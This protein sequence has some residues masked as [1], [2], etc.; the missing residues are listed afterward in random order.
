MSAVAADLRFT[1]PWRTALPTLIALMLAILLLYRDTAMVMVGIWWRSETFAH[2]W[3]VP[4]ISLWLIWRKRARLAA[5]TPRAE[6]WVLVPL[7]LAATLWLVSDV[8]VV[9]AASQFAM[10]AMLV[11]AVP[12]VLGFEVALTIL[13]PLLYLFFGVPFGEFVVPTMIEWTADFTVYALQLT[14][15]PVH[16]EGNHFVIPSGSWSVI[17]ECSGVRYLMASF[18]VG[19]LFAY[20]NYR[21]YKRRALFMLSS[22]VVPIVANWLRAYMIVMLAHMSDNKIAAG[23]DHVLYGWVFFGVIIFLMFVIGARWSEPDD[24]VA[25]SNSAS[26]LSATVSYSARPLIV[27][28]LLGMA[29]AALPH[30]LLGVLKRAED[31]ASQAKVELPVH[32]AGGW[33]AEGAR[34]VPWT[35]KFVNP[36]V[37]ATQAYR[38]PAGTVGVHVAYYRGQ[39][40]ERKLVNS[41][42]VLIGMRDREW[43]VVAEGERDVHIGQKSVGVRTAEMLASRTTESTSRRSHPV[44]W[45]FY[46][47]DGRFIRGSVATKLAGG[48]ARLLGRGDEGAA[49]VLYADEDTVTESNAVLESFVQANLGELDKLLQ[50]TRDAR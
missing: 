3:L 18:M 26:R 36:S 27:T 39:H 50:R 23:V 5:L 29:I 43:N 12:A 15:I 49:L 13:F 16:R 10:V 41:Q 21:S 8:V 9:N 45:R 1:A 37:L 17:D 19:S 30:V 33:S 31:A 38:G 35:P 24:V 14:G 46:W 7:V 40:E 2:C 47:V 22:L 11:L 4:P 42:N 32:L 34:L 48:L 6:P 28:A 44:I 20:L 25:E